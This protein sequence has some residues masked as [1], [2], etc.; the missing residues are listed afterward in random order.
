MNWSVPAKFAVLTENPLLR[1]NPRALQGMDARPDIVDERHLVRAHRAVIELVAAP[2]RARGQGRRVV[3]R[4]AHEQR[5]LYRSLIG[6]E[7]RADGVVR[8]Y[9]SRQLQVGAPQPHR[10]PRVLPGSEIP[11]IGLDRALIVGRVGPR[12]VVRRLGVA[13]GHGA[14]VHLETAAAVRMG[15]VAVE[16]AQRVGA[17]QVGL[18]GGESG[19]RGREREPEAEALR[20]RRDIV[21]NHV[22]GVGDPECGGP[23]VGGQ[24][25]LSVGRG[26]GAEPEVAGDEI[27]R[28]RAVFQKVSVA[29]VVVTD[30]A[31][32][33]RV[34][35][36]MHGDAAVEALPHAAAHEVLAVHRPHHVPVHRVPR[37]L[38]LLSHEVQLDALDPEGA[39]HAHH[40]AAE[41]AGARWRCRPGPACSG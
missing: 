40:V 24:H 5:I 2:G 23:G 30:V 36:A 25:T 20:A 14:I 13:V 41:S 32:H 10:A 35:G 16:L 39:T 33:S 3:R 9:R 34:V 26:P 12:T 21:A 4:L 28:L 1:R 8:Q 17:R 18:A 11:E 38:P 29:Q 37:H 31:F 19:R 22:I 27:A 15:D 7:G 6:G